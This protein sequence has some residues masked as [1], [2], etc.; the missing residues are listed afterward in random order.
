MRDSTAPEGGRATGGHVA[1][2]AI[3][4]RL[5]GASGRELIVQL[6]ISEH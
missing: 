4:S 5:L 2:E 3:S 6:L 1:V